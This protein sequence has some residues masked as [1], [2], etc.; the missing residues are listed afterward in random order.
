R[1]AS[2]SPRRRRGGRRGPG[3][4]STDASLCGD[5]GPPSGSSSWE[6]SPARRKGSGGVVGTRSRA[7]PWYGAHGEH[8]GAGREGGLLPTLVEW[9]L[10]ISC[11]SVPSCSVQYCRDNEKQ[12]VRGRG[13]KVHKKVLFPPP[14][15]AGRRPA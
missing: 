9:G 13:D 5:V 11:D 15:G 14:R 12:A 8:G 3:R 10:R 1:G 2:A 7:R 6:R 4:A